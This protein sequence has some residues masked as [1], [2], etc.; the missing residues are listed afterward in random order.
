MSFLLRL[1]LFF[2]YFIA[3]FAIGWE[4][5]LAILVCLIALNPN[6]L[7]YALIMP[8]VDYAFGLPLGFSLLLYLALVLTSAYLARYFKENDLVS[9]GIRFILIFLISA[10]FLIILFLWRTWPDTASGFAAAG[11]LMTSFIFYVLLLISSFL[12]VINIYEKSPI[13]SS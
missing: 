8:A 13:H 3:V 11:P 6:R 7:E 12:A 10:I 5:S 4:F 9:N 1:A 2:L